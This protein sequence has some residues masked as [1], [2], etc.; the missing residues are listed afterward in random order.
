MSE[1]E[2]TVK[3]LVPGLG[4]SMRKAREERGMT[5]QQLAQ[6]MRTQHAMISMIET[7]EENPSKELAGRLRGWLESGRGPRSKAPRG[8]YRKDYADGEV[9]YKKRTT[10]E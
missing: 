6:E 2:G 8:P 4:A 5:V 1:S 7:G 9:Q 3:D 10:I